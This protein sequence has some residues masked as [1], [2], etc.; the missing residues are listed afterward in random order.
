MK[1]RIVLNNR[2]ATKGNPKHSDSKMNGL[3]NK[4]LQDHAKAI[5]VR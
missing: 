4:F 5:G 3:L 1:Q 2:W